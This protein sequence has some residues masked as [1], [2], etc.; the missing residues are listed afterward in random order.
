MRCKMKKF[1]MF[2]MMTFLFSLN[3]AYAEIGKEINSF[4]NTQF[5][6]KW[7]FKKFNE[8][9][10]GDTQV[11][12]YKDNFSCVEN[13]IEIEMNKNG[14]IISELIMFSDKAQEGKTQFKSPYHTPIH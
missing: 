8:F 5:I 10:R 2:I 1:I 4:E 7:G 13:V 12:K 9:Q 14:I 3:L 6:K 11:V